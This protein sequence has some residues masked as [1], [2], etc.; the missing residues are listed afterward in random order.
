LSSRLDSLSLLPFSPKIDTTTSLWLVLFLCFREIPHLGHIL[1][2]ASLFLRFAPFACRLLL[3]HT[4]FR[5]FLFHYIPAAD[6][7]CCF[8]PL[9]CFFAWVPFFPRPV[10]FAVR[11]PDVS[12]KPAV[13]ACRSGWRLC[14]HGPLIVSFSILI[15]WRP[16]LPSGHPN[17]FSHNRPFHPVDS[18]PDRSAILAFPSS[19]RFSGL[20]WRG[21]FPP[22][23][24][25]KIFFPF[26][27]L[28]CG[29]TFLFPKRS[30]F[31]RS[32]S[33]PLCA[34]ERFFVKTTPLC[35]FPPLPRASVP[36]LFFSFS[37]QHFFLLRFCAFPFL[38]FPIFSVFYPPILRRPSSPTPFSL[39][40]FS[41][42]LFSTHPQIF[43]VYLTP[44]SS[45]DVPC[46]K[47]RFLSSVQCCFFP[48]RF[49]FAIYPDIS[50]SQFTPP[51]FCSLELT[52][53]F[54]CQ[55]D[56]LFPVFF[57]AVRFIPPIFNPLLQVSP[58]FLWPLDRAFDLP[59]DAAPSIFFL[60]FYFF[61]GCSFLPRFWPLSLSMY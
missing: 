9:S 32:F 55:S 6:C 7:A 14:F 45:L 26:S 8:G 40:S 21:R 59:Q 58:V 56:L 51:S 60:T 52:L 30:I 41:L 31:V 42:L 16:F 47:P 4:K 33:L 34:M 12:F 2:I 44:F 1:F 20:D 46:D 13:D 49:F 28:R 37:Q 10:E 54:P 19:P 38:T 48:P 43:L 3:P 36:F 22:C 53:R 39:R 11:P 23:L 18:S 24:S 29:V 61:F 5:D 15:W 17:G 35:Y 25:L 57:D 50:S 27:S